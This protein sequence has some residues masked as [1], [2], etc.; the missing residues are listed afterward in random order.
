MERDLRIAAVVMNSPIGAVDQNLERTAHWARIARH[1]GAQL[2]CFPELNITGYANDPVMATFAIPVPGPAVNTLQAIADAEKITIL[3]GS[4]ELAGGRL[5]A[6][7]LVLRPE[8]PVG[9]Y[10][11]LHIAPPEAPYFSAGDRVPLFSDHGAV[12][13]IQLCFDGHFPELTTQMAVNGADIVFIPHAS[14]R[15]EARDKHR[16]WMRHLPARAYDNGIF[17]VACNQCGPNGRGLHFPGNTMVIGPSGKVIA[18]GLSGEEGILVTDLKVADLT[19]VRS[20][21]MRYFLPHRR[22]SVYGRTESERSGPP[23]AGASSTA[24]NR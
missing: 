5:F 12:F 6:S 2:I 4:A 19:H 15:G 17:V 24:T 11:K 16:S 10:R 14:P 22:P 7:H 9:V 13:G 21:G 8:Q 23:P 1:R 20:H 3:A 18:A